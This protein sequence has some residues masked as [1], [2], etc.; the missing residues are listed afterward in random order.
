MRRTLRTALL[1]AAVVLPLAPVAV[2]AAAPQAFCPGGGVCIPAPPIQPP[3]PIRPIPSPRPTATPEPSPSPIVPPG[4][5]PVTPLTPEDNLQAVGKWI[6]GG[7]NWSVCQVPAQLGLP[8]DPR[9]CPPDQ[10]VTVKLPAPRDW[11]APLYQRMVEIAGLLMLPFLLLAFLQSLIRRDAAMAL[12]AAFG[13]APLA[14]VLSAI[15]VG[16]TQSVLAVSD[17]F[18]D[19]ML[20]GYQGQVAASIG[21]LAGVLALGA[22]GSVFTVGTS[23]AAVIAALVAIVAALA[24]FFE[25]LIRQA[26]IYAAVLFLPLSFAAMVWPRLWGWTQRL[27]EVLVVAIFAKFLIVSVLVLGAAAFTSPPG[28]GPFDSQ[29]PP[30]STLLV[31]LLL[32][33]VAAL[34]PVG[35]FWMLPSFETA[36]LAQFHGN[37]GRPLAA[38]PRTIE[39]SV[40]HLGLR[41]LWHERTRRS[42]GSTV[43]V[44]RPGSRVFVRPPR[45][46]GGGERSRGRAA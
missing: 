20:N 33:A 4:P 38:V 18:S 15:A 22:A 10:A 21:S 14:V 40:Y 39:Q 45:H 30:G 28:G 8:V 11:F 12:R 5:G 9:R 3:Q 26:L 6:F 19:F 1:I 29:A 32:V 25:L 44:L 31:G 34:S 41:R 23:A 13:Y 37:A 7:A 36:V 2:M 42:E 16:L 24:I 27:V 46:R 35:L 43:M 17:S